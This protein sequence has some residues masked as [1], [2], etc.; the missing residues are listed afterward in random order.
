ML[1]YWPSLRDVVSRYIEVLRYAWTRR[2][3]L[4]PRLKVSQE[5]EFLPAHLEIVETPIHPAPLWT[6]RAIG[7]LLLCCA[8][9]AG[10]G[11]LDVVAV[12]RGKL[13]PNARVKIVQPAVT[14][15]VRNILVANGM[16]VSAGQLMLELDPTQAA[17]DTDKATAAKMDAQLA[18]ARARALLLAQANDKGPAVGLVP[19]VPDERQTQ[20]QAYAE[21]LFNEY[22][23][24]VASLRAQLNERRAELVTVHD[25]VEK[26]Q[27]TVPLVRR[28][29]KDYESLVA[30]NYV[31]EHTYLEKERDALKEEGELRTSTDRA[32]ALSAAV[33]EQKQEIATLIAGFRRAQLADLENAQQAL[34]QSTD[35]QAKARVRESLM[36]LTAPVAGTVQNLTVHTLGGV[37]TTAQ[38]LLEIVPEDTLEV[39]AS[40]ANKDIGFVEEGQEAVIKIDAFPYTRFGYLRGKVLTVAN[41]AVEN[42]TNGLQYIARVGLPTNQI[43]VGRKKL[44]LTPGMQVVAEIRTGR[45][46]VAEYLLSPF[47]ETVGQSMR[48]R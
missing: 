22:R 48:E 20:V 25:E 19:G 45:R 41:D 39:E 8:A 10:F 37:V 18:A 38:S 29:A 15:V 7:A 23:D 13:V 24:K 33:E 35:D 34:A 44:N 1:V 31:A 28:Q 12:A 17:A 32:V 2:D 4:D 3:E 9:V 46:T 36:K 5:A 27:S 42:R 47:T 30:K 26:L 6:M 14:G 21:G 43:I 40:V 11:H 16:H